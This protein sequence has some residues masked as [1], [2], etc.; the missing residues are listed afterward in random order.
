MPG[1]R[2]A[3][4]KKMSAFWWGFDFA[5]GA[6]AALSLLDLV[7]LVAKLISEAMAERFRARFP[8]G[9]PGDGNGSE[10]P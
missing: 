1:L 3:G 2:G 9:L 8:H 5:L 7:Q 10:A 6:S 4:E